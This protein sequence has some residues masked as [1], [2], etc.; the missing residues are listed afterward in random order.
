[1]SRQGIQ[2]RRRRRKQGIV[3]ASSRPTPLWK[4][5]R[6]CRRCRRWGRTLEVR[7]TRFLGLREWS[8]RHFF[9][10]FFFQPFLGKIFLLSLSPRRKRKRGDDHPHVWAD[11]KNQFRFQGKGS[12]S[13]ETDLISFPWKFPLRAFPW[14][15]NLTFQALQPSSPHL[16]APPETT[17]LSSPRFPFGKKNGKCWK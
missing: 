14:K 8:W 10:F 13:R 4:P 9:F 6:R 2:R 15:W 5:K 3:R 1:M 16:H 7:W 11:A 12:V 17:K